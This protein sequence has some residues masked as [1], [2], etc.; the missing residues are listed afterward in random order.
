MNCTAPKRPLPQPRISLPPQ[1][2]QPPPPLPKSK[3][4]SKIFCKLFL[5]KFYLLKAARSSS[6]FF[7][8]QVPP[9]LPKNPPPSKRPSSDQVKGRPS[10]K[11]A[12]TS[13]GQRFV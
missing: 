6:A 13:T 11:E 12:F 7:L 9:P 2:P 8:S 3:P 1:R 10:W 5:L 4:P